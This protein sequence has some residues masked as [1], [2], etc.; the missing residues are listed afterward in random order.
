MDGGSALGR[1]F[2]ADL[3][4]RVHDDVARQG[5]AQPSAFAFGL[6]GKEGGEYAGLYRLG[7]PRAVVAE[8]QGEQMGR[9]VP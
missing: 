4:A 9:V 2:D 8:G 6:G 3:A 1:A 5:Q 7:Y